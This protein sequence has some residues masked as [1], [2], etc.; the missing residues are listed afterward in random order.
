MT[1]HV[2]PELGA[3]VLH[4]LEAPEERAVQQHLI[5]CDECLAEVGELAFTASLLALLPSEEVEALE[6]AERSTRLLRPAGTARRLRRR[7]VLAMAA[8]TL[9]GAAAVP[10]VHLL[11]D[12]PQP[13]QAVVLHGAGPSSGTRADVSVLAKGSRTGLHLIL[14]GAPKHRWCSLVARAADGRRE[15]AATWPAADSGHV[16]VSGMTT[17]PVDLLRE[18]SVVTD[19]GR[20]LVRIPVPPTNS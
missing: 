8:T 15:I 5:G 4:A 11:D 16:D 6:E 10:A 12:R 20:Q 13:P 3:F 9:M 7:A 17:I 1:C 19:S 2:S 14:T 18:I